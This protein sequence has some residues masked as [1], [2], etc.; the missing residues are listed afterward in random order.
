MQTYEL[1]DVCPFRSS[2]VSGLFLLAVT[3]KIVESLL[4]IC[5]GRYI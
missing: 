2:K 1:D 4:V 5:V 3:F